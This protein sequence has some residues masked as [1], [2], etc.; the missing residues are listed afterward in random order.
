MYIKDFFLNE[1]RG[2]LRCCCSIVLI[3]LSIAAAHWQREVAE[4]VGDCRGLTSSAPLFLGK[5]TVGFS[6]ITTADPGKGN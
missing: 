6:K 5:T 4:D 3:R 2:N 1:C